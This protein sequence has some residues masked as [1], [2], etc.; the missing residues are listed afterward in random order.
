M[1][2]KRE[3]DSR[4]IVSK[5]AR[6]GDGVQV[7]AFAI[8]GDDV[9]LGDGCILHDHAVVRGPSKLGRENRVFSFAVVGGDPQDLTFKG[10]RVTLEVGDSNQFREFSTINRGTIK[11]G[12]V[13]RV[14]SHNLFMS[15]SH[16]G[17]DSVVGEPH[18]IC[19]RRNARGPCDCGDYATVG[20]FSPVHQFCRVGRYAYIGAHTVITQ[21]VPPFS[22]VV[23]PRDT[24]CYGINKVGLERQGFSAERLKALEK[25]YRLLLRS[26]L[27]TSQAIEKMREAFPD[28]EDVKELVGFIETAERGLV[29]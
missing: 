5:S 9:E 29:K 12:G 10:E 2:T 19:K 16:V 22:K 20:N 4:A 25:A 18:N 28:S 6:L 26:K 8:V 13:T 21:D 27:N 24:S 3:I 11:G 17:H 7:G 15:Y 23:T 14:G 1:N